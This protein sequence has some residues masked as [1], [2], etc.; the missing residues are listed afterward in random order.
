MDSFELVEEIVGNLSRAIYEVRRDSPD[1]I[2]SEITGHVGRI[3]DA[4]VDVKRQVG[5]LRRA[6]RIWKTFLKPATL[7]T[8]SGIWPRCSN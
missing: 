1:A 2:P 6:G 3:A 4:I 8:G 7:S 5:S